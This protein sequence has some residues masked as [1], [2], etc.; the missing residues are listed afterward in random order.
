M[1]GIAIK[2]MVSELA[3]VVREY[4][5]AAQ[6]PLLERIAALESEKGA[7][8]TRCEALEEVAQKAPEIDLTGVQELI[9]EEI[10]NA[11]LEGLTDGADEI[12]TTLAPL[13]AR[14]E[15]LE[16]VEM[17]EVIKGDPG[18][19]G[20]SIT[21]DDVAP[22]I[23]AEVEKAVAALPVPEN[24]KD[25]AGIVEVLKDNGELV[26]TLQDG[27]LVRTGIRDGEKGKDGRD[28]FDLD[29]FDVERGID[30]RTFTL[31]FEQG[32]TRHEYELTFPVVID[33]GVWKAGEEYVPGDGVTWG[34]QW[35]IC[36]ESTKDLKPDQSKD[37]KPW[38]L[39]VRKGRDG[40]DAK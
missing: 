32:D 20:T 1:D 12:E 5:E 28:G 11:V 18:E 4:V 39:A 2:A 17:P 21:L 40:K 24:G 22:L 25:A 9:E 29:A 34:G 37:G 15:A 27:R 30:G 10:S 38:R 35:Y 36:Q 8:A 31:K 16:A 19:D 26:L 6:A 33:A 13:K 23:V 14:L 7:L 3:P